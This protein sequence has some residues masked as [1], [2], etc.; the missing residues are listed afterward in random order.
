V[1][2]EAANFLGSVSG[3]CVEGAVITE[4]VDVIADGRPRVLEFGVADE[5]MP[6]LGLDRHTAILALTHDSKI[7]DSALAEALGPDCFY[8][9]ARI[10]EIA[11]AAP[12]APAG[13]KASP[14]TISHASMAGGPQHRSRLSR[15]IAV[16]ILAEIIS[17]LRKERRQAR[18]AA[19]G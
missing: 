2:D 19:R 14:T 3:G 5:A 10:L 4:A 16:S 8:I 7:D 9:G 6:R 11:C 12:G 13:R 1:V 18:E 17:V 15:E